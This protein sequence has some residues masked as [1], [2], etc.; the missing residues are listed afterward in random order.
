LREL[1]AAARIY[2]ATSQYEPFGLAPVEA[3][4]SRCC[5]VASDI[6]SL[7]EIWG[8]AAIYFTNNDALSL[9]QALE[10]LCADPGSINAAASKAY[11]RAV[12]CYTAHRMTED[13][14]Q[15]YK[16]LLGTNVVAA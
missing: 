10:S 5:I 2:I 7:R 15:L 13:Y 1:L 8:D 9:Q 11:R 3:A 16:N 14:I 4:F 6:P 12:R